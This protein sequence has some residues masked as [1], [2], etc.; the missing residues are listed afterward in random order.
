MIAESLPRRE[1]GLRKLEDLRERKDK[2]GQE[3]FVPDFVGCGERL[4]RLADAM[5][6]DGHSFGICHPNCLRPVSKPHI[7][8]LGDLALRV[9]WRDHFDRQVWN[10]LKKL[11]RQRMMQTLFPNEAGIWSANQIGIA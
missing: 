10:A 5:Y 9:V 3:R 1:H 6:N 11:R 7:H 8:L 2:A 4:Q